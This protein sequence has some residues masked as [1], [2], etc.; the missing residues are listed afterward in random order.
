MPSTVIR[1]Y[2]Y[3]PARQELSIA[4]SSGRRYVY[5]NVPESIFRG[6]KGAFSKGEFF[7]AHI[8]ERFRFVRM[9][10]AIEERSSKQRLR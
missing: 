2:E 7:N 6:M 3:D 10:D 8:R 5:L 4:F 9:D 1:T